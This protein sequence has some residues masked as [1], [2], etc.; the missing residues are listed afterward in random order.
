MLVELANMFTNDKQIGSWAQR[1][2]YGVLTLWLLFSYFKGLGTVEFHIDESHWIATSDQF[3]AFLRFN[4]QAGIWDESHT[5]LTNPPVPRYMIAIGRLAGGFTETELNKM[6]DYDRNKNYN[7]KIGAMPSQILL[8]WSRLPMA[9]LAVLAVLVAAGL[10]HRIGGPLA[11][12]TWMA[13]VLSNPYLN[14]QLRR[15]MAESSLIFFS[16]FAVAACAQGIRTLNTQPT[17]SRLILIASGVFVGLAA[18]AKINAFAILGGIV[19][20]I[21]L[22]Y[23]RSARTNKNF[24]TGAVLANMIVVTIAILTFWISYPYLWANP[25]DRTIRMVENRVSEMTYQSGLRDD[26]VF[27]DSGQKLAVMPQRIWQDYSS[28][29]FEGSLWLN[30]GLTLLGA[31]VL[32]GNALRWYKGDTN[33]AKSMVVLLSGI[34][35]SAPVVATMLDWDRY[36]I[37]P[38]FFSGMFIA[39]GVAWLI[40]KV[41]QVLTLR[42]TELKPAK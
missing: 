21:T 27:R 33:G 10:L 39:A 41:W 15:A 26:D 14:L 13:L 3:E 12:I 16:I 7:I 6:W 1:I 32:G 18:G 19:V 30:L 34:S 24:V 20:A 31:V 28:I 4:P 38:V 5:T 2:L 9:G 37:Y 35:A 22:L 8:W 23:W 29:R 42:R 25:V 40:N 36:Y 17:R 11:G